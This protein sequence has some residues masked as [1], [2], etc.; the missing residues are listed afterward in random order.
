MKKNK[1]KI[2]NIYLVGGLGNQLFQFALGKSLESQNNIEVRFDSTLGFLRDYKYKRKFRLHKILKY[3]F[4]KVK[5]IDQLIFLINII[6]NK[7]FKVNYQNLLIE[8]HN[9]NNNNIKKIIN[10]NNK[11]LWIKGYWQSE[12]YFN[13]I[14]NEIYNLFKIDELNK[15]LPI[16]YKTILSKIDHNSICIC[17]RNFE[18]VPNKDVHNLGGISKTEFY[19]KAVNFMNK[20]ITNPRYF[21]FS[22]NKTEHRNILNLP[23]NTIEINHLNGYTNDL[24]RLTLL[25]NFQNH[26]IS[27]STFY[28]WS[29]WLAE[30]KFRNINIYCSNNFPNPNTKPERWSDVDS[31]S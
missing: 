26:I 17:I 28:W 4:L 13:N 14:S 24:Y 22:I 8:N 18:E 11:N 16:K 1:K 23:S 19:Q 7:L 30:K 9:L 25:A 6:F 31:I 2:I 21:I 3:S 10:Q 12:K 29:A 5:L 20:K 15:N 27:N